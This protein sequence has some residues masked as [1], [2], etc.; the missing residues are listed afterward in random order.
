MTI[1]QEGPTSSIVCS[2]DLLRWHPQCALPTQCT[3]V[4]ALER[5]PVLYL[6]HWKD[7]PVLYLCA[8]YGVLVGACAWKDQ[9]H[10]IHV[11]TWFPPPNFLLYIRMKRCWLKHKN[12]VGNGKWWSWCRGWILVIKDH[13]ANWTNITNWSFDN[14]WRGKKSSNLWHLPRNVGPPLS[15][16]MTYCHKFYSFIPYYPPYTSNLQLQLVV[17][18][19]KIWLC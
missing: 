16:I 12:T 10:P 11:C 7:P 6:V 15:P 13:G 3:R 2:K 9:T 1:D 18:K 17:L 8:V 5:P 14:L 4:R 19:E